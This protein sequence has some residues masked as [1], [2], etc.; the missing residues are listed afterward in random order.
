MFSEVRRLRRDETTFRH[1]PL[2]GQTTAPK[3]I[4]TGV[5]DRV[6]EAALRL[7][8]E[9]QRLTRTGKAALFE[10]KAPEVTGLSRATVRDAI[11]RLVTTGQ[12]CCD[13]HG[14]LALPN[15]TA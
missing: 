13:T 15:A 8:S 3:E 9:G 1:V 2:R 10:R 11:E 12:L 4:A 6:L 7:L 5:M 14:A